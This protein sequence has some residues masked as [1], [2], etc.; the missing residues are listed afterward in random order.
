[1]ERDALLLVGAFVVAFLT[2]NWSDLKLI[3]AQIKEKLKWSLR[4]EE[5]CDK[6]SFRRGS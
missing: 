5:K 3:A 6:I 2:L 4:R 1:M